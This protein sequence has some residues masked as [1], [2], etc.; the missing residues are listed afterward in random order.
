VGALL[1]GD[2]GEDLLRRAADRDEEREILDGAV[3]DQAADAVDARAVAVEP[4]VRLGLE[5]LE[6]VRPGQVAPGLLLHAAAGA[7]DDAVD[8]DHVDVDVGADRDRVVEPGEI[9]GVE[10]RRDDAVEAAVGALDAAREL[11]GATMAEAADHRLGDEE[12]VLARGG[13][14]AEVLAVADI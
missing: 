5:Q 9:G 4:A 2:G 1:G 12:A 3:D 14:R 11:D 13:E 8:A 7:A 10:A 6:H